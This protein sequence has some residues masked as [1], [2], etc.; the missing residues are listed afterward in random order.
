MIFTCP[1]PRPDRPDERQ[2]NMPADDIKAKKNAP[3]PTPNVRAGSFD[4]RYMAWPKNATPIP[5][6]SSVRDNTDKWAEFRRLIDRACN[7]LADNPKEVLFEKT[8]EYS[9]GLNATAINGLAAAVGLGGPIIKDASVPMEHPDHRQRTVTIHHPK[10]DT[11]VD[12]IEWHWNTL[13]ISDPLTPTK[14]ARTIAHLR[15]WESVTDAVGGTLAA[16]E[17]V[18]GKWRLRP[19]DPTCTEWVEPD[20]ATIAAVCTVVKDWD[21]RNWDAVWPA[22]LSESLTMNHLPGFKVFQVRMFF[23]VRQRPLVQ[24]LGTPQTNTPIIQRLDPTAKPSGKRSFTPNADA[25]QAD[26]NSALPPTRLGD[27]HA[28]ALQA[29]IELKA[30][31]RDTRKTAQ[32]I[33]EKADGRG[34]S[35]ESYKRAL[36]DLVLWGCAASAQGQGGGTWITSKGK[37]AL[38]AHNKGRE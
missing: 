23:S 21:G 1:S 10:G 29:M 3:A 22:M 37:A 19:F 26:A 28:N 33:A 35:G 18:S 11:V 38:T 20:D 8:A 4:P 31:G 6:G 17:D 32:E 27:R 12:P 14:I 30:I 7:S 15:A 24:L 2:V 13:G 16:P 5:A 36:A 34:A 25:G 9:E